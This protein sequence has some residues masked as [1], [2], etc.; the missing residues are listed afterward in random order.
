MSFLSGE[1]STPANV[2]WARGE[3]D[4]ATIFE[5]TRQAMVL[6]DNTNSQWVATEEA[7]DRRIERIRAAT[8]RT[9]ENPFRAAENERRRLDTEQ[10]PAIGTDTRARYRAIVDSAVARFDQEANAA[11]EA[12]G[13]PR[14]ALG[15]DTDIMT[16][17][18]AVAREADTAAATAMDS[19][20][21][22]LR[23]GA[24]LAGG[25]AGAVHDPLQIATLFAGGGP[26]AARTVAGKI[27]TVAAKEALI[28]GAAEA[29]LQPQVQAWREKAGLPS[30]FDEAMRNVLFAAGLGAVFGAG[31][32]GISAGVRRLR[33]QATDMATAEA[34]T[35]NP[36]LAPLLND[37][38]VAASSLPEIRDAL[39]PE[40]RG[41]LDAMQLEQLTGPLP[42]HLRPDTHDAALAAAHRLIDSPPDAALP[43]L[44]VDTEQ[45]SRV[46]DLVMGGTPEQL[47]GAPQPAA[48]PARPARRV[49][50][51]DGRLIARPTGPAEQP[52]LADFIIARGG[53]T[54]PTGE[55]RA[56]DAQTVSRRFQGRLLKDGG[57]KP[58][59]MRK[60]AAEAGYFDHLYG[61][62]D[63]AVARSTMQDF[64]DALDADLRGQGTLAGND[65]RASDM[66]V[67]AE[68]DRA[69]LE[70]LIAD[71]QRMGGPGLDDATLA[72]AVE[73]TA[74]DGM[75]PA[76]ALE[77]AVMELPEP[78]LRPART[79]D[80]LPGWD[81]DSL[82]AASEHRAA[83]IE[84]DGLDDPKP[85][86]T[87]AEPDPD[88][89]ELADIAVVD[90]AGVMR[91]YADEIA[92]LDRELDVA[93]LI[94]LCKVI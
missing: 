80:P 30:G 92:A 91:S 54:D 4:L 88:F 73:L 51:A 47:F 17:A 71:L 56:M 61:T 83:V 7:Y 37:P 18:G 6:A 79:G 8:G 28:N 75:D 68:A 60:A 74:S 29:A 65:V 22:W 13:A 5:T 9:L 34:V 23:W 87:R 63:Q 42:A 3:A 64:W 32:E 43:P 93:D 81:D 27:L 12:S 44:R 78:E 85:D 10:P 40:A 90:D 16:Q 41:A 21:G 49:Q 89:E 39:P 50:T 26:G 2:T 53:M 58:D 94:E 84:P 38:Q 82:I 52:G 35:Q 11:A 69:G 76:D 48:A 33:S 72:R 46:A 45:T 59:D 36:A 14:Q 1:T 70:G 24:M 15:I 55:A 31:M 25:M 67:A 86:T 66:L 19:R 20:D 57:A 77:R 62:P